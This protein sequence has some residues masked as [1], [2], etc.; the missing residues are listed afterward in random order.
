MTDTRTTAASHAFER[1]LEADIEDVWRAL[2]DPDEAQ[3]HHYEHVV[4]STWMPGEPVRYRSGDAVVIHG[5]VVDVDPPHRLVH[6]FAFTS[7][8]AAGDEASLVTWTLEPDD[9]GTRVLLVH[10]GFGSR[11][12]SWRA[13][14]EA[15]EQILDGLAQVFEERD[16]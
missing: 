13:A 12:A 7:E 10:E 15:W 1:E 5:T 2:T 14:E 8:E 4:D 9:D 11:N 16:R 3:Q 6:T